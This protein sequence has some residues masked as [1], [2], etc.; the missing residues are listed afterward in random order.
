MPNRCGCAS[1][2]CSCLIEGGPGIAVSGAGTKSNP[3]VIDNTLFQY[4][5]AVQDDN[6]PVLAGVSLLDFQG[7]G[8]TATS[9]TGGEVVVTV[10]GPSALPPLFSGVTIQVQAFTGNGTWTKPTDLLWA[11][12]EVQ[13]GGGGGGGTTTTPAANGSVGA[14]GGGG[15]YARK[16]FLAAALSA[17]EAVVVGAAGAAG[18]AS[19]AVAG[20]G[21]NSTFHGV[22]GD[23]GVGG[24]GQGAVSASGTSVGGAGGSAS[25]GDV[26]VAG[27]GGEHG[28]ITTGLIAGY[29]AG[30]SSFLGPG[31]RHPAATAFAGV[32]GGGGGGSALSAS[33][34]GVVG[35]AGGAGLVLV[36]SYIKTM[37]AGGA[38]LLAG[39]TA[40]GK[41]TA[42]LLNSSIVPVAV[43][44]PTDRFTAPP[45]VFTTV[46]FTNPS[47]L[48]MTQQPTEDGVTIL[49]FHRD[50]ANVT[51]DVPVSWI[52]REVG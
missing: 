51:A 42:P 33:Q 18:A 36:T 52:A 40:A 34:T 11:V 13:G 8:V 47:M 3:F 12:V 32:Q 17:T 6:A 9:G 41:V 19:N 4:A 27:D 25:G 35:G 46:N 1:E 21:G 48:S 39:Q 26:N 23:G 29:A 5:L 44:F 45:A 49:V 10:P 20:N 30:G 37:S 7:A 2:T 24:S 16:A 14:G 50:G 38:T 43:T 28:R 15:G 22:Q 31:G